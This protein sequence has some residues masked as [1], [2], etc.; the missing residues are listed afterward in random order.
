MNRRSP[1]ALLASIVL[2]WA[3]C[4]AGVAFAWAPVGTE[5]LLTDIAARSLVGYGIRQDDR[6]V[7]QVSVERAALRVLVAVPG[8]DAR[9]VVGEIAGGRVWL[10]ERGGWRDLATLLEAD[11]LTLVLR[12]ADGREALIAPAPGTRPPG[13]TTP[14]DGAGA[15][16][17]AGGARPGDVDDEHGG[18]V[19]DPD[20]DDGP[21][22]DDRDDDRDDAEDDDRDDDRDD[23]EDD[24]DDDRDDDRDDAGDD[25]DDDDDDDAD[26]DDDDD[27]GD[28]DSD[29]DDGDDD[30][31]D[32][33]DD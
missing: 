2:V 10:F 13:A 16:P 29:E 28:G 33:D 27:A 23:A 5:L 26:D 22:D 14:A 6:L 19:D 30:P 3:S 18:D 12:T 31:D 9:T 32:D 24:A 1:R 25:A 4:L 11:G 7:L 15:T 17:P 21:G 8:S 20:D